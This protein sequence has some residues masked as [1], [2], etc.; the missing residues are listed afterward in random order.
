MFGMEQNSKAIKQH[1]STQVRIRKVCATYCGEHNSKRY[2]VMCIIQHNDNSTKT[3]VRRQVC[4][5]PTIRGSLANTDISLRVDWPYT[6]QIFSLQVHFPTQIL[7]INQCK[8]FSFTKTN[9]FFISRHK[10][11][12]PGRLATNRANIFPYQLLFTYL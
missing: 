3:I 9:P 7:F 10:Y 4:G 6:L 8:Y 1:K 12:S 11:H 2:V 5:A